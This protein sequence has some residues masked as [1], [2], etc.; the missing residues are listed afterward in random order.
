MVQRATVVRIDERCENVDDTVEITGADAGAI[1]SYDRARGVF[2]LAEASGLDP[3]AIEA[4]KAVSIASDD[5]VFGHEA[6][7]REAVS[8]PDVAKSDGYPLRA[9]SLAAGFNSV[10][11]VPLVDWNRAK[12]WLVAR[13]QDASGRDV[14][15]DGD[16][17]VGWH[18]DTGIHCLRLIL[19]GVF[20]RFPR[21]QFIVG[22]QF[23]A[24]SWMAWRTDYSF[25]PE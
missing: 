12:P 19:G 18:I 16:L 11:V 5:P 8:I 2:E 7:E 10:L 13:L 17:R 24:L 20:D 3:S 23:E 6:S 9:A 25:P 21:L 14:A 1:F 15:I 4:I 22:H